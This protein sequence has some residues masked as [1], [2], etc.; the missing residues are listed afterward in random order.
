[1][2]DFEGRVEIANVGNA[3]GSR[4]VVLRDTIRA[5]NVARH[6][7]IRPTDT[8]QCGRSVSHCHDFGGTY[9][10]TS[11]GQARSV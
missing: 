10:S 5:S 9:A 1:M 8:C 4:W 2:D 6:F 3:V 11:G 7:G